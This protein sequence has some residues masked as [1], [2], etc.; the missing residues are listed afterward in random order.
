[1]RGAKCFYAHGEDELR[2]LKQGTRTQHSSTI[3]ELKRKIFVG[4]L[5]PSLDSG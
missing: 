2:Q 5:P 1:M 4:G 3:E